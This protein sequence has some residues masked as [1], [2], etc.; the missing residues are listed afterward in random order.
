MLLLRSELAECLA[1]ELL[2]R[3]DRVGNSRESALGFAF[4]ETHA[5]EGSKGFRSVIRNG[6][7]DGTAVARA[8]SMGEIQV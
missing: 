2:E 1:D 8:V 7:S 5:N 3:G 4:A 6:G